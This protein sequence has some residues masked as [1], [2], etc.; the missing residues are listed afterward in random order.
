DVVLGEEA[1]ER[2]AL[3]ALDLLVVELAD[4][5][6]LADHLAGR[7]RAHAEQL[8]GE[9]ERRDL[10]EDLGEPDAPGVR[11]V[12][13]H[14]P[15]TAVAPAHRLADPRAIGEPDLPVILALEVELVLV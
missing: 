8:L 3:V 15:V 7:A 13:H 5:L 14:Q 9:H 12:A 6:D 1:I 2:L 4:A 11:V 10:E